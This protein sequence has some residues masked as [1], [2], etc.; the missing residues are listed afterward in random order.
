MKQG[1]KDRRGEGYFEVVVIVLVCSMLLIVTLNLFGILTTRQSMS[2]IANATAEYAAIHG[3]TGENTRT[4]FAEL[5]RDYGLTASVSFEGS[6]WI[7]QN[8]VQYGD[9]IQ[10]TVT[11]TQNGQTL[12]AK[13]TARSA[14]YWK[15][16]AT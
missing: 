3:S 8:R 5:C 15:G 14:V 4:Y 13:A 11:T 7:A 16:E 12:T 6:K 10:V 9:M 2:Q 1:L